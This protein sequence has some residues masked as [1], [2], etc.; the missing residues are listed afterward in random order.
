MCI[1]TSSWF[2]RV[3]PSLRPAVRDS[4]SG[5]E[6]DSADE[7][8]DRTFS[9]QYWASKIDRFWDRNRSLASGNNVSSVEFG[10]QNRAPSLG[11][12]IPVSNLGDQNR[13]PSLGRM[14]PMS[15]F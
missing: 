13:V 4:V 2:E 7:F 15:S 11:R 10:D 3:V 14:I 9:Q 1:L 8:P 12:M 5:D 6:P